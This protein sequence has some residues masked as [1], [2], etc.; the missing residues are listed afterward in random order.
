MLNMLRKQAQSTVIQALVLII[1]IVFVF[2]G[3]GANLGTQRNALATVNGYEIPYEEYQR[4]YETA[5]DNLRVQFGGSVPP[6]LLD[7]LGMKQQVL[8]QLI[9]AEIFRQGGRE[10]GIT[11]SKLETQDEI[12][13]ME[14]FQQNGL[15]DLNRYEQIL[16]QNRMTPILFE[17]SLRNDLLTT[18]VS[19]AIQK[20]AILPESEIQ[21]RYDFANEQ[22][23]LA[24]ASFQSADFLDQVVIEEDKLAAW[25]EQQKNN[26]LAEP[27]IRLRYLFFNYDDDLNQLHPT[28]EQLKARYE[29]NIK[30]YITPEQRRARHILFKIGESDDAQARSEKKSRAEEVLKMAQEG[31]DFAELARQNSEDPTAP[32]GG[33]LGFFNQGAMVRQFDE[34]VFQMQ[35]GDVRGVV[36]TVF[37]F[38]V[39]KLEEIRPAVTRSFDEVKDS[40]AAEMNEEAVKGLTLA[41][42]R[43][44]YEDIIRSGS[45]DKYKET[46]SGEVL[47]TGYFTRSSPPGAPFSDPRLLQTAF[48][49]KK[50]ELSSLVHAESGYAI[51]FVDDIKPPAV[52]ELAT[53]R[54]KVTADYVQARSVEMAREAAASALKKSVESKALTAEGLAGTE[55]Q[56]SAYIK[57]SNPND[58]GGLPVQIVQQGFELSLAEPFPEQPFSQGDTFYVFQLLE[59]R[60]GDESLDETQRQ[61]L[62]EQLAQ[63]VRNRLLSDWLAWKQSSAEIWTNEQL[64]R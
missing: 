35:P 27:Q 40:I 20:F 64:L 41:R 42:A 38:H 30:Q 43:Q 5:I 26:Y 55:L 58:A 8:N 53:V 25:F 9:Q 24:Y 34:T 51:L 61:V 23:R 48:T 39:I 13:A 47:E 45:L 60:Q 15:F 17:A 12:K 11:V 21:S 44:A 52:P 49:L 56:Q 6:G 18:K 3:V 57:R 63:S 1:A 14:V 32:N 7:G 31:K 19:E 16:S 62:A 37:G 28:E 54:D 59:K 50:G 46:M 4:T 29:A 33:D 2:W 36:E 22:I 10:M